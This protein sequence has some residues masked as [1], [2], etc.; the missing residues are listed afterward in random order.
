MKQLK[1]T[2]FAL[3]A[4]LPL[5]WAPAQAVDLKKPLDPAAVVKEVPAVKAG[6]EKVAALPTAGKIDLNTASLAQLT[7]LKGI[8]EKKAQ[9]IIDYRE[10]VGKFKSVDDLLEV[11]GIGAATLTANKA[12]IMVK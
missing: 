7:E 10:K 8:G 11:K 1:P 5:L 2:L 9:A 4:A 6:A 12:L 3:L